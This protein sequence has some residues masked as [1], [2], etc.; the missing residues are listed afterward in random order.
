MRLLLYCGVDTH[1][2]QSSPPIDVAFPSQIE[3]K[4]NGDDVRSNFKGLKNKPGSTKPADITD[5]IRRNTG[6]GNIIAITYALTSKQFI[7]GV[8]LAKYCDAATLT[9]RI[10]LGRFIPKQV[11]L[12]EMNKA[13]SDPDIATTS[14]R[15]SLKDP[16]STMRI[17]LPIRSDRC[18]HNQCFDGSMFMQLQEQAP[19]WLCPVCNRTVFFESLRVDKYFEDILNRTPKSTEKVDIEPNGEWR[20][21][22]AGDNAKDNTPRGPRAAYDDDF[23]DDDDFEIVEVKDEPQSATLPNGSIARSLALPTSFRTNTP[24]LSSRETSTTQATTQGTKRPAASSR[25][26]AVMPTV[27]SLPK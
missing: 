22:D 19:Q 16:V 9:E 6:Y 14:I 13:N 1:L 21:I 27:K 23:D 11:V 24:P 18:A 26:S 20:V 7:F 17:T 5:K 12:D 8:Q 3:V 10:K 4:I 25:P 2:T 15:M